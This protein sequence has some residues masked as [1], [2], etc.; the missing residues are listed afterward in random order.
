M[1]AKENYG[2]VVIGAGTL[3]NKLRLLASYLL[4]N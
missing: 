2:V 4:L 3:L 1:E